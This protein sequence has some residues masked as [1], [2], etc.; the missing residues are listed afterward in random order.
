MICKDFVDCSDARP[1]HSC[2]KFVLEFRTKNLI[3]E[4]ELFAKDVLDISLYPWQLESMAAIL[5]GEEIKPIWR[6]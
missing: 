5:N 2:H 1:F 4:I 6:K 3:E